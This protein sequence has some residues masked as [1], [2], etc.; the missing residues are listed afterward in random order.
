[1]NSRIKKR[2]S[3]CLKG[4]EGYTMIV[5][6]CLM[7]LFLVLAL[8]LI[9]AASQSV[10]KAGQRYYQEQSRILAIS[11]SKQVERELGNADST[12]CIYVKDQLEK[13]WPYYDSEDVTGSHNK[14]RAVKTLPVTVESSG[15]NAVKEAGTLTA[16]MYWQTKDELEDSDEERELV[17]VIAAETAGEKY[18]ITTRY[19]P[20]LEDDE[21]GG[22]FKVWNGSWNRAGREQ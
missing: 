1:M 3:A 8:S 14:V 12:A 18:S 9:L 20:T 21:A 4:S 11:F 10:N 13:G 15:G 19:D 22:G 17:I 7:S 5:V 6:L 2:G 16:V